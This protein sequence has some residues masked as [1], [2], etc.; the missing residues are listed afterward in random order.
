[1][2]ILPILVNIKS[3]ENFKAHSSNFFLGGTV[4]S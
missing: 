2:I 4:V 1:M 3:Q